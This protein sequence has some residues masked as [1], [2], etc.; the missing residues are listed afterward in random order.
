MKK[1]E[2]EAEGGER[3]KLQL[4]YWKLFELSIDLKE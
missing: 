3:E 4:N 2:Q 1:R